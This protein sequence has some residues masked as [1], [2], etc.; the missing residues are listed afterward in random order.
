[1]FPPHVKYT[2]KEKTKL[3]YYTLRAHCAHSV[4]TQKSIPRAGVAWVSLGY[5]FS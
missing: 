2:D 4:H 1:M 3:I 5:S